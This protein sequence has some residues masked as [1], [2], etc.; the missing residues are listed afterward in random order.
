MTVFLF[1]EKFGL[2]FVKK[3]ICVV[4]GINCHEKAAILSTTLLD[5]NTIIFLEA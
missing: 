4:R 1:S 2:A 3:M 5:I